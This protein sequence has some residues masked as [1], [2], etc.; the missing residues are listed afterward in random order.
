MFANVANT[1]CQKLI[2]FANCRPTF[3]VVPIQQARDLA[4]IVQMLTDILSVSAEFTRNVLL[5]YPQYF[6]CRSN[7]YVF[8]VVLLI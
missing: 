4:E 7:E 8:E 3:F 6:F 5:L 1:C 2:N